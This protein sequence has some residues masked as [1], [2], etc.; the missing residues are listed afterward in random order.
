MIKILELNP[1][2]FTHPG[3][4]P[5]SSIERKAFFDFYKRHPSRRL[6]GFFKDIKKSNAN[7]L[8]LS[9][10]LRNKKYVRCLLVG[11]SHWANPIDLTLFVQSFKKN[12]VVEVT[13]LD[14]LPDA[15]LEGIKR[16]VPFLPLLSPAQETPFCNESFDILI[17]DGLLNCCCFEQHEPIIKELHRIAKRKAIII[18]GLTHSD[19]DRVVKWSERPIASYSRPLKSFKDIFLKYGV[20]FPNG[21]S[22][23]TPFAVGSGLATDNCIARK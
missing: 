13:A 4:D 20:S 9:Q 17:A 21:S 19:T 5:M 8:I 23:I 14:V 10:Y 12:I 18:L 11:C 22:I 16:N 15:L 3:P 2:V 1:Q 6:F 7:N